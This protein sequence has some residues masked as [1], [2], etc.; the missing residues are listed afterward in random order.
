MTTW[1]APGLMGDIGLWVSFILTLIIFSTLAGDH[2]LT[3]LVQYIFVGASLGYLAVLAVQHILLPWLFLPLMQGEIG[4][5]TRQAQLW[6]G[7]IL[8][9]FLFIA[10]FERIIQQEN[11]K[12]GAVN[13]RRWQKIIHLFGIAAVWLMLGVGLAVSMVGVLEG[14]LIPQ[15][16]HTADT[17]FDWSASG[18]VLLTTILTLLVTIATL[19]HLYVE[20]SYH[21]RPL[22]TLIRVAMQTLIW[23]G[24][25]ALWVASGVVFARLAASR[26]SLLIARAEFILYSLEETGIWQ[27]FE[28]AWQ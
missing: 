3:R 15:F 9:A 7:L 13:K 11:N 5:V 24:K 17:S 4:G 22:P 10:G 1:I 8:G 20:P 27:W 16:L 26:F 12:V 25:R 23:F 18:S 6:G 14:T 19:L 2:Q 21:L 28:S